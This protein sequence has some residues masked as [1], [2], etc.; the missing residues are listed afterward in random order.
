MSDWSFLKASSPEGEERG[1]QTAEGGSA[2]QDNKYKPKSPTF[3]G[4]TVN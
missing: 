2:C 4:L 3:C 1:S